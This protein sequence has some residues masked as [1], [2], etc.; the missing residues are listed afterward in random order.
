MTLEPTVK[1]IKAFVFKELY[2]QGSWKVSR[3]VETR[4]RES[5]RLMAENP[6]RIPVVLEKC[7]NDQEGANP[8]SLLE[9]N[10]FSQVNSLLDS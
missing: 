7:E 4:S 10:K 8:L 5:S 3:A 9:E 6:Q 1:R 2:E